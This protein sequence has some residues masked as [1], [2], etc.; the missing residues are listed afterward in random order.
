MVIEIVFTLT[1]PGFHWAICRTLAWLW[2]RH[3]RFSVYPNIY[4][5]RAIWDHPRR[6]RRAQGQGAS[7]HLLQVLC[8]PG[9]CRGPR[10]RGHRSHKPGGTVAFFHAVHSSGRVQLGGLVVRSVDAVHDEVV[11]RQWMDPGAVVPTIACE[12]GH[13]LGRKS[14]WRGHPFVLWMNV[15][16]GVS[17]LV[18]IWCCLRRGASRWTSSGLRPTTGSPRGRKQYEGVNGLHKVIS[19][20]RGARPPRQFSSHLVAR[21]PPP[22]PTPSSV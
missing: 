3:N 21:R 7:R 15:S 20:L 9:V 8:H 16:T 5:L 13:R 14:V 18:Y 11:R 10:G 22:P 1:V 4:R 6:R 12:A 17:I 2:R 19:M